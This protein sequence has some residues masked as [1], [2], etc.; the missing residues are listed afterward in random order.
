MQDS[1]SVS[2][3]PSH[4]VSPGFSEGSA[5][6]QEGSAEPRPHCLTK[7]VAASHHSLM[8][9]RRTIRPSQ[10]RIE[11]ALHLKRDYRHLHTDHID[12]VWF[13]V[14]RVSPIPISHLDL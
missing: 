1:D 6:S 13:E 5:E 12:I 4:L 3:R 9:L 14:E 11:L 8:D 2:K 10:T 7:H